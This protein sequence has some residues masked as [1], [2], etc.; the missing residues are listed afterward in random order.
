MKNWGKILL[1]VFRY[2]TAGG[3]DVIDSYIKKLSQKIQYEY[4]T[5]I[6]LLEAEGMDAFDL[7]DTKPF[8]AQIREIRFDQQRL[9]YVLQ[10]GDNLYIL[11]ACKKEKNKT[12]KRDK[13]LAID[14]AKELGR[15]LNKKFV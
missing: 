6:E 7:L 4:N 2:V 1:N 13:K 14:R 11:H 10:D 12:E 8:K 5:I 9:F 3:K 15:E